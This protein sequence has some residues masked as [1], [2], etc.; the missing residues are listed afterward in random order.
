MK[1]CPIC[2]LGNHDSASKCDCGFNFEKGQIVDRI[3][4]KKGLKWY[5]QVAITKRVHEFQLTKY[6][7]KI[8]TS[9]EAAGWSKRMTA[10][11]LHESPATVVQDIALAVALET[12]TDLRSCKTKSEAQKRLKIKGE[13]KVKGQ[14]TANGKEEAGFDQELR[15]QYLLQ[16]NW[17]KTPFANDWLLKGCEYDTHEIGRIDLLAQHKKEPRWLVIELKLLESSDQTVGQT[18]RYMGWVKENLS[19]KEHKVEGIIISKSA[20]ESIRYALLCVP[21][22]K[23]MLYTLEDDNMRLYESSEIFINLLIDNLTPEESK[24]LLQELELKYGDNP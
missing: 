6:G 21:T 24:K 16:R 14:V 9:T 5:E 1:H 22:I 4:F 3:N 10:K 11:L 18:L 17:S 2:E 19:D 12:N 15:L 20:G 7:P 8:S 23:L 13:V